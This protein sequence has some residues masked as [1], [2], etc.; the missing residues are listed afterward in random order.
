MSDKILKEGDSGKDVTLL[1]SLMKINGYYPPIITGVYGPDTSYFI[2]KF[3]KD[4]NIDEENYSGELT[5]NKLY[6]LTENSNI[7]GSV[8][9]YPTLSLGSTSDYVVTLKT[10]LTD[11]TYYQGEINNYFEDALKISV[12]TFQL[13]NN[14]VTDGIVGTLTWSSLINIYSPLAICG[15]E[16]IENYNTYIVTSGD[17]LYSIAKKY[18][19]SVDT[20]KS[21]NSL[22]TETLSIGQILKVPINEAEETTSYTVASGDT[23]YSIANKFNVTVD[24]LKEINNL[25]SDTLS[26]GQ[27]LKITDNLDDNNETTTYTVVKGDT[28]YKIASSYNVTIDYLKEINNLTSDVLTI[29]Q[30]L[31]IIYTENNDD[32][33]EYIVKSGDTLYKIALSYNITVANLV[34]INNLSTSTLS[35]GQVLKVPKSDE[36]LYTVVQGDTLYSIANKFNTTVNDLMTNNSLSTNTLSIGQKLNI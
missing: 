23:L 29:G 7:V 13:I 21:I 15:D 19:T 17:T 1:Q 32:Y 16:E 3:Q 35:I 28:L 4:Y 27:I 33:D 9:E 5:I 36:F 22:S 20:L 31:K 14:L 10:I 18:N 24:Y 26:I 11:M 8:L 34:E 12:Q 6:E 2:E 30:V 25:S